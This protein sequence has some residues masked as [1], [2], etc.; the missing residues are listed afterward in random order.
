MGVILD[1]LKDIPIPA[2]IKEKLLNTEAE[3]VNLNI[4]LQKVE[5][6]EDIHKYICPKCKQPRV[7]FS[8]IR[9]KFHLRQFGSEIEHYK[10]E[11]CDHE[12][13][14]DKP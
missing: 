8:N 5:K 11:N 14:I 1:I 9:P 2:P 6:G 3:I 12:Y 7:K 4:I 10:C 13:D